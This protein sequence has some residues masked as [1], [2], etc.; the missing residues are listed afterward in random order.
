MNPTGEIDLLYILARRVLLDALEAL[1]QQ[2]DAVILAGAQAVYLHTGPA[3]LSIP[4]YTTDA[5]I[6][7]NPELLSEKP[8]LA[9]M[10]QKAGFRADSAHVGTWLATKI[11]KDK[12][13]DVMLD[14]LVP[15]AVGGPRGYGTVLNILITFLKLDK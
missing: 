2:R 5:D 1:G 10:L 15:E 8:H 13:I 6:A 9:E 3:G 7:F 12:E 4:E 14:L 11:F